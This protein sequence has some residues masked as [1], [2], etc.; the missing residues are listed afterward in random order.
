M[1]SAP[2]IRAA[3]RSDVLLLH[4]LVERGYRGDSARLGWTHQ[5]DLVDGERI[6]IEELSAIID[7]PT[8]G[9]LLVAG[10][11]EL[12]ACVH[13]SDGGHGTCHLELLCV[14]PRR[15]GGGLGTRLV[16]AAEQAAATRFRATRVEMTVIE[17]RTELIAYYGRRGYA[18][19]GER[20]PFPVEGVQLPL[21][22]LAKDLANASSSG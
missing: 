1:L 12:I 20:R 5:A 14:D 19:A 15:Q 9:I 22:V 11:G 3:K 6:D 18:P 17:C 13:V 7:D 4:N 21:V 8:Q 16:A 2:T 10:E